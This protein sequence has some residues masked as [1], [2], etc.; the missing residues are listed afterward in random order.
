MHHGAASI[1]STTKFGSAQALAVE[2]SL[3]FGSWIFGTL[4]IGIFS[5]LQPERGRR[6]DAHVG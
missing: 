4:L 3:R 5:S 2:G 6:L 1:A